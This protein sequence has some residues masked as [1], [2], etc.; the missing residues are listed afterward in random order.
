MTNKRN[1][2][3][4]TNTPSAAAGV[5]TS[6]ITR[7]AINGADKSANTAAINKP[8]PTTNFNLSNFIYV[9][10]RLNV[11]ILRHLLS[12]LD[13]EL[14]YSTNHQVSVMLRAYLFRESHH[15]P[16]RQFR[17]LVSLRKGGGLR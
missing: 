3:F 5:M 6:S 12:I 10:S 8:K 2:T 17:R 4:V 11:F 15:L 13:E 9:K 16:K 7:C 14:G 1:K